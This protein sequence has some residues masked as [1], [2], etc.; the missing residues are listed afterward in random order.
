MTRAIPLFETD[1]LS[2]VYSGVLAVDD[3]T[4]AVEAGT[5]LVVVGPSGSGKTTLL[6]LLGAQ[7]RP[8]TGRVSF[9]GTDLGSSSGAELAR[10]RRR[11][12]FVFQDFGLVTS[13]TA[14]ENVSYPLIPRGVRRTER[15]RRATEWLTRFG[16][17]H[18]LG[19]RAG[20][21][22]GG[23]Q[24][25][26]AIAR[27]VAGQP[28]AILAD[29]PTSNLDA[30]TAELFLVAMADFRASGGTAV[31]ASHDARVMAAATARAEMLAGRLTC[32]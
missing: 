32:I 23:E 16:L 24:Q 6:A 4:L 15:Q 31:I 17:G 14:L 19:E 7:E 9:A 2:K 8:T 27:A 11:L 3:V 30:G 1:A 22:S 25:R 18:K 20:N 12:G 29:E 26:V 5:V 28:E 21:L 10:V 13:L